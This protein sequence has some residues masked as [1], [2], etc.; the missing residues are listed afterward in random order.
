MIFLGSLNLVDHRTL[1]WTT[2]ANSAQDVTSLIFQILKTRVDS[3]FHR[4][5]TM[6]D[7]RVVHLDEFLY[8]EIAYDGIVYTFV[9]SPKDRLSRQVRKHVTH[10]ARL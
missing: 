8:K 3:R 9:A 4:M 1:A 7:C 5:V 10:K 6:I 2:L